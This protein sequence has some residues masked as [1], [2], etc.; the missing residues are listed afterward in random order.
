MIVYNAE[1]FGYSKRAIDLW[2]E[3]G[4]SYR[5]GSWQEIEKTKHFHRVEILIVRLQS[6]VNKQVLEKF[7]DIRKLISATTGWDHL[8]MDAAKERNIEVLTLRGEDNFLRKIP[9]TAEHTWA[10]LMSLIRNIPAANMDVYSGNWNRDNFRGYQL[11]D[12]TIGIIGYGRTGK[13]VATYATTFQMKVLFYDPYVK[14]CKGSHEKVRDLNELLE[15]SDIVSMHVHLSKETEGLLNSE[16]LLK[17]KKGA[18]LLNTSRGKVWEEKAIVER[19][20]SK[21]IAGIAADVVN[22]EM[23]NIKDSPLW[24]AQQKYNNI[25][26][27]PHIGGATWDAMWA[28][29]EFIVNR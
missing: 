24:Q 5:E 7:P 3:K 4:Y 12:K 1:P 11:I 21:Q 15:R 19:L 27:T 22:S 8:D 6:K 13:Q 28:C 25:I 18:F 16:N 20:E 29:E 17:L 23:E 9:S 14:D 2:I 26:I 10:L